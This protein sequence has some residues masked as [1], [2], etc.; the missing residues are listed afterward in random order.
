MNISPNTVGKGARNVGDP[1]FTCS[2]SIL[3]AKE[4]IHPNLLLTP[5]RGGG[6]KRR[7]GRTRLIGQLSQALNRRMRP[8]LIVNNPV[9]WRLLL[10]KLLECF[11]G[12]LPNRETNPTKTS[13]SNSPSNR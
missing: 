7:R 4:V 6:A 3:K 2:R 11:S 5:Q 9:R 8:K 13:G 12:I 10:K 1:S